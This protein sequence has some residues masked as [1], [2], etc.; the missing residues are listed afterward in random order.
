VVADFGF[1]PASAYAP[2][3]LAGYITGQIAAA[4][5]VVIA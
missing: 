3:N 1:G 2:Q 5:V 4:R